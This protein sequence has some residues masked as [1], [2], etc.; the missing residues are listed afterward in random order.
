MALVVSAAFGQQAQ[1]PI[2]APGQQ[3]VLPL[4]PLTAD[5]ATLAT[6]LA[7]SDR[8]VAEALGSG[9]QQLIRV[10]FV[11]LKTANFREPKEP[12]QLDIGRHAAVVFYRYDTDKGV[13]VI[14]D[15]EQKAVGEITIME[16]KTVPLAAA[17][18]TEALDLALR[19]EQVKTLLGPKAN[20]FK[21]AGLSAG[22]KPENRVEGLRVIASSPK[23]PCYKHRCLDLLF[24][25]REGYLAGTSVSVDLTARTVRV[26]RTL[27]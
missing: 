25:R 9:K 12:E 4:D 7:K 11:A 17:E 13:H 23:D 21:V 22:E 15:L 26:E 2:P 5:E 8:K 3:R 1:T 14:I 27:K 10:E 6:E 18:V 24:R 20:E 16:G 19:N